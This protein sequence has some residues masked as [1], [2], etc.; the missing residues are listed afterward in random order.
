MKA[1]SIVIQDNEIS[2]K[3]YE[4][5]K[6]STKLRVDRFDAIP[7]D[8]VDRHLE[9]F[10]LKWTYPWDQERADIPTGLKL[11]P[12]TTRN[13]RARISCALSHFVL[14]RMVQVIGEPIVVLE[15]DAIFNSELPTA[16]PSSK[17]STIIGLNDPRGATRKSAL[18]H[19]LV[20][21]SE[22][23]FPL[24]PWVDEDRMVPQGLAGNSAYV[25]GPEG[26]KRMVSL[27]NEHG[28]W[29]ND[30]IMCRQLIPDLSTSKKYYTKVQGTPS[31]T[32]S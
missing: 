8:Q 25:I 13:P 14:W 31:T 2:E 4:K 5:L 28:L 10:N 12:Y 26:G 21:S 19:D 9:L 18:Y 30:A 6:Q 3:A 20:Q 17:K 7:L 24:V 22:D 23:N 15:H 27:V 32:S 1:Y 29:P 16:F 11:S